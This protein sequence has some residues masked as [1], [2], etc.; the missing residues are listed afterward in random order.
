[1]GKTMEYATGDSPPS[2]GGSGTNSRVAC[3]GRTGGLGYARGSR[4]IALAAGVKKLTDVSPGP[5]LKLLETL[6]KPARWDHPTAPSNARSV[7]IATGRSEG[8]IVI[9]GVG[10]DSG[11]SEG[12][13]VRLGGGSMV[14]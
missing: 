6:Q 1:M 14:R 12:R 3:E 10:E 8:D 7:A 11:E 4:A 13:A 9:G 5:H 2:N